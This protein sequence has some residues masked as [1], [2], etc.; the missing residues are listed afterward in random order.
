MKTTCIKKVGIILLAFAIIPATLF[1]HSGRTDSNG[2]HK[3]NKNKSGLGS[4]HYHCGG[5]PAHLHKNGV[6]PYSTSTASTSTASTSTSSTSTSYTSTNSSASSVKS[7]PTYIEKE[8][9]FIIDGNKVSINTININNTNLV[10]LKTL[11]EA[12][13]IST[14]YDSV[15]KSIECTKGSTSF[16]L[17]IDSKNL[18]L[19]TELLTLEVA[20]VAWNGRTMVPARVVA[21]AIGSKVTYNEQ[22]N[23]IEIKSQQ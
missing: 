21:E 12:L 8:T 4:Y 19:N 13:G 5:H 17:Q 11:C 2:G 3:D 18:W 9:L 10:E 1:A 14:A 6:C 23:S 15:L 22:N 16:T 20:P 7:K